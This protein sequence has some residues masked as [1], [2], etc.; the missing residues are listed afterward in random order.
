VEA[1]GRP[2]RV[3]PLRRGR[4]R[5]ARSRA[6]AVAPALPHL[7]LL[8]ALLGPGSA[9]AEAA[10]AAPQ[11]AWVSGQVR[12]NF[13]AAPAIDGAP[14]G[15]LTSG[16]PVT[17]LERRGDWARV[18]TAEGASGWI[19]RDYLDA[20]PPPAERIRELEARI[21]D[22]QRQ[23]AGSRQETDALRE[24]IANLGSERD[25]RDERLEQLRAENRD[26]RAG[27]RWPYLV[28]GASILGAGM[29]AGALVRGWSSRRISPRIR[30]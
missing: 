12:V 25:Q 21:A 9:A 5:T 22:L 1:T 23:L 15:I 28:T 10:P 8:V 20:Q 30:F 29:V 6:A 4:S 16:D 13:R 3:P 7:V 24:R 19:S 2:L 18:E 11:K 14:L 17:I 27:E 26:L